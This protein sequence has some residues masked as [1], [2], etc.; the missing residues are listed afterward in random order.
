MIQERRDT[1]IFSG[2]YKGHQLIIREMIWDRLIGEKLLGKNYYCGY[3]EL[4]PEDYYFDHIDEAE[5]ELQVYGGIT[6][7]EYQGHLYALPEGKSFV[8]FDTAHASRSHFTFS[9][10][11]QDCFSLIDQIIDKNNNL[12]ML[13]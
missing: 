9:M 11:K 3:A 12:G 10:V 13:M 4:L 1:T 7:T 6:Y 8:G 5:D 2:T